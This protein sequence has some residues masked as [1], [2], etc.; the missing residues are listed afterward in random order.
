MNKVYKNDAHPFA[1][2]LHVRLRANVCTRPG[3]NETDKG[4]YFTS[5]DVSVSLFSQMSQNNKTN[6][7]YL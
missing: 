3:Q 7:M 2:M 4:K 6:N 5:P 1:E